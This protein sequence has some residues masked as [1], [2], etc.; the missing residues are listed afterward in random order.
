MVVGW[1]KGPRLIEI[2]F[3]LTTTKSDLVVRARILARMI[4]RVILVALLRDLSIFTG[5]LRTR[6]LFIYALESLKLPLNR[7]VY[8]SIK[9][10]PDTLAYLFRKIEDIV[11]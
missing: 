10:N 4:S 7:F 2:I 1:E 3:L 6:M 8:S 11:Q 9:V 5:F